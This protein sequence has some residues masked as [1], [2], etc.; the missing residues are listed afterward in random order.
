MAGRV[1][2]TDGTPTRLRS[3]ADLYS[4]QVTLMAEGTPFTVLD[5]PTCADGYR[6]WQLA[7]DDGT[8]GWAAE[9]STDTY[10]LEP[11][12]QSSARVTANLQALY[13]FDEGGGLLINDVSGVGAPMDLTI[14]NQYAVIWAADGLTLNSA[15]VIDSRGQSISPPAVHSSRRMP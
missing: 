2:I 6:W 12:T 15:T 4:E 8:T 14:D 10:F 1:T 13:T 9:A 7:L 3:A 5:G 11:D